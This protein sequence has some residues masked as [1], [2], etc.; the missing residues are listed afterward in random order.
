MCLNFALGSFQDA[1]F[2]QEW[3][4]ATHVLFEWVEYS[5]LVFCISFQEYMSQTAILLHNQEEILTYKY[6]LTCSFLLFQNNDLF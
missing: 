6:L 4:Q 5:I 1:E 2:I 3:S